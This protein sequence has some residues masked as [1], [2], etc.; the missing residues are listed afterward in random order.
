V[1]VTIHRTT[2]RQRLRRRLEGIL[3]AFFTV[4]WLA[5]VLWRGVRAS[6]A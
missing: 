6:V 4:R 1:N 5:R 3:V 2:R